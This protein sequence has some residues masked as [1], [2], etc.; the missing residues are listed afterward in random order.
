LKIYT[1]A[2]LKE[3]KRF[4]ERLT[5]A[6]KEDGLMLHERFY[7]F[8]NAFMPR[9][10]P[11]PHEPEKAVTKKFMFMVFSTWFSIAL[12]L[13]VFIQGMTFTG[14]CGDCFKKLLSGENAAAL[15]ISNLCDWYVERYAQDYVCLKKAG[16]NGTLAVSINVT[17]GS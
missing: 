3:D 12:L 1:D 8:M 13:L 15:Q 7:L 10:F 11:V 16:M 17:E 14:T 6:F 4:V 5:R 9:L 2:D